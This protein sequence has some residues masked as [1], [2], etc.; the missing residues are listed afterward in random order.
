MVR[1]PFLPGGL[2]LGAELEADGLAGGLVLPGKLLK[3]NDF[4]MVFPVKTLELFELVLHQLLLPGTG[5][6]FKALHKLVMPGFTDRGHGNFISLVVS[7]A[8]KSSNKFGF[9]LA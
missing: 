9:A 3:L 7:P 4:D 2:L 6:G 5:I 1:L 8:R